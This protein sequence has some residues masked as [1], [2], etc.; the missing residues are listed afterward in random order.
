MAAKKV[1]ALVKLQIPAGQATPAPP[2]GSWPE[3][4]RMIGGLLSL[5]IE[6]IV[7][8]AS[9]EV[10]FDTDS[11]GTIARRSSED[12]RH[13]DLHVCDLRLCL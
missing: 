7:I 6:A 2:V 11:S 5:L 8:E 9:L 12:P 1:Q 10:F 13:E 4:H 3:T